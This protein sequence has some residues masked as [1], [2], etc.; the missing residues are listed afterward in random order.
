MASSLSQPEDRTVYTE[1]LDGVNDQL[2]MTNDGPPLMA[3]AV[4]GDGDSLASATVYETLLQNVSFFSDG[5]TSVLGLVN[6]YMQPYPEGT[7]RIEE[8]TA[9]GA[10]V[11]VRYQDSDT[12]SLDSEYIVVKPVGEWFY[13]VVYSC[14]DEYWGSMYPVFKESGQTFTIASASEPTHT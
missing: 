6:A 1:W 14:E 11:V 8:L 4:L 12:Q 2:L 13:A 10:T 7:W 9:N 5:D 3:W